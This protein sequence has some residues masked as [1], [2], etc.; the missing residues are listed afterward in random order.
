MVRSYTS[1]WPTYSPGEL[2]IALHDR[3]ALCVDRAKVPDQIPSDFV[4]FD[5]VFAGGEGLELTRLRIDERG[6]LPPLLEG[7]G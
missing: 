1:P 2:N 6:K 3:N 5:A 7:R 4:G